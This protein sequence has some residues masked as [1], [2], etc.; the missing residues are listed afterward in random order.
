MRD[1]YENTAVELA[2]FKIILF[3]SLKKKEKIVRLRVTRLTTPIKYTLLRE[4]PVQSVA[5][6]IMVLK[7][8]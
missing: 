6:F 1:A 3:L 5:P 4:M 8:L 2:C 7:S